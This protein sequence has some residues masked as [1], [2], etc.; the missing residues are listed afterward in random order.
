MLR[1]PQK[2]KLKNQNLKI[3]TISLSRLTFD[4]SRSFSQP[5]L[6]QAI[7]N[8][9]YTSSILLLYSLYTWRVYEKPKRGEGERSEVRG[10]W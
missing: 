4:V 8:L 3:K 9:L 5:S 7:N 6:F 1:E 10:E 2:S